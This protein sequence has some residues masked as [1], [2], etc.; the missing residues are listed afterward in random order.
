MKNKSTKISVWVNLAVLAIGFLVWTALASPVS[1]TAMAGSG[2]YPIYKGRAENAVSLQCV[3]DW[4]AAGM[5]SIAEIL[6]N[7]GAAMTFAVSLD[8]VKA[9]GELVKRLVSNG[10]EIAV[11][12][13]G[14]EENCDLIEELTG[15]RPKLVFVGDEGAGGVPKDLKPVSRTADIDCASGMDGI[16]AETEKA[17]AAGSLICVSPTAGF[18]SALP[19]II[20]IIKNMGLD[21]VPTYKMLYN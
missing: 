4:D 21:I 9:H 19:E 11:L 2:R 12:K 17:L 10:S 5:E 20:K 16:K 15:V 13:D 14:A 8:W 1:V 18:V 6:E 3:V 7:E